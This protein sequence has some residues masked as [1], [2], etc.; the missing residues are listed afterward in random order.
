MQIKSTIHTG[1]T[2]HL[3]GRLLFLKKINVGEVVGKSKA[4]YTVGINVK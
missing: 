1:V 3:L 2:S 4:L